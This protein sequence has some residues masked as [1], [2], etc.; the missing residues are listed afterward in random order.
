MVR[1]CGHVAVTNTC[2]L[3]LLK[4]I[5]QFSEIEQDVD[6]ETGLIKENA[7]QF[8]SSVLEAPSQ[9]E[10]EKYIQYGIQKLNECGIT[11][12]Q[13]DDLASLPGKNWRRILDAF[14]AVDEKGG[15]RDPKRFRSATAVGYRRSRGPGSGPQ[16]V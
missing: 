8:Y 10:I 15:G 1:V 6:F 9:E 4:K 11:G 5:P 12:V 7:V 3:E 2:G 16:A 13:S 14:R